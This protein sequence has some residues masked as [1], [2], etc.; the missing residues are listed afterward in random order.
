MLEEE[1]KVSAA[2]DMADK[3][4]KENKEEFKKAQPDI[5][6][7]SLKEL[8]EKNIK[9]SQV[10]YNQNKK[11]KRR[12]TMIVVGNYL[13]LLLI[14]APIIFALIYLPPLLLDLFDQYGQILGGAGGANAT[15]GELGGLLDL[16]KQGG[17]ETAINID[18]AQLKELV[19]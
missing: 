19:K 17:G 4:K 13:R 5:K 15:L 7:A 6:D 16:L 10:I 8:V 2:E 12:L 18:P 11:I 1:K 9:W 14:A 3:E